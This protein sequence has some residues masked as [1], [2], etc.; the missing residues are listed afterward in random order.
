MRAVEQ[1]AI[2]QHDAR[3]REHDARRVARHVLVAHDVADAVA[4]ARA[5]E[6]RDARREAPA[7]DAPRLDH[8]HAR[9][10][11]QRGT[12]VDLPEPV[13]DE[14]TTGPRASAS[15][16]A[17]RAAWTGSITRSVARASRCCTRESLDS[18][19]REPI[20]FADEAEPLAVAF[21]LRDRVREVAVERSRACWSSA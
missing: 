21:H 4:E 14:S 1:R 7:R 5:F 19:V 18:F 16:N 17:V 9:P 6:L 20:L 8:Q 3:R 10:A 12:S 11:H 2:A 13:G 15:R